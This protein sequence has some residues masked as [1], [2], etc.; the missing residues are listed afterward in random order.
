MTSMMQDHARLFV[1]P[2]VVVDDEVDNPDSGVAPIIRQLRDAH[3]P[4]VT[5]PA[6]PDLGEVRHWRAFSMIIL[7]WDLKGA[8]RDAWPAG[9]ARPA[10][11]DLSNVVESAR[12]VRTI[13][14]DLYCPI[15]ILSSQDVGEIWRVLGEE[16]GELVADARERILVQSKASVETGLFDELVKWLIEKPAIYAMKSWEIGYEDAKDNLFKDLQDSSPHWPRFIWKASSVDGVNPSFEL[17]ETLSR[18]IL[19]RFEPLVFDEGVLGGDP[20]MEKDGDVLRRVLH[21]RSVIRGSQLHDDVLMPGDFFYKDSDEDPKVIRVSM[22]PSCDLVPRDGVSSDDIKIVLVDAKKLSESDYATA[23]A[24]DSLSRSSE[25]T[26]SQ[27]VHV[28]LPN[29][30]PYR[31]QFKTWDVTTWGEIRSQRQGRLLDPYITLLQQ[32][33]GLHFVRQGLPRLPEEFFLPKVN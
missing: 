11:L 24:R 17:T 2:A 18:N 29:G 6:I 14:Q 4:L 23:K 5:Q 13:L 32:K 1:G 8:A 15:F 20:D 27:V 12:F 19:H 28:F 31:V 9:V 30:T 22:T 3:F 26:H 21:R 33:F 16:L 7:D 25:A 10:D